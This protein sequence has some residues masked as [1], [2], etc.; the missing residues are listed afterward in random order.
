MAQADNK[1]RLME[2]EL[3]EARN[4]INELHGVCEKENESKRRGS[5]RE[6]RANEKW[7]Q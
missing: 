1:I 7:K 5:E 3:G 2:N 4:T 6:E